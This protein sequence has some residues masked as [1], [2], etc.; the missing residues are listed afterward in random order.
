MPPFPK[1]YLHLLDPAPPVD[2][3]AQPPP[4]PPKEPTGA[5]PPSPPPDD[6]KFDD[7]D[8]AFEKAGTLP[9][10]P[11][12]GAKPPPKPEG[13]AGKPPAATPPPSPKPGDPPPEPNRTPKELRAEKDR[14]AEELKVEKQA[15]ADLEAK[16]AEYER[17]GK[18]TE[19]LQALLDQRQKDLDKLN[20]ELRALKQE[21]SPEFKEKYDKPFDR[22]AK[23]AES[24][25]KGMTKVDGT[26]A[27]FD[28]DFVPL[29]RMPYNAAYARAREVFGDDMAPAVMQ[30][31]AELQKLDFERREAFEEE[32]KGWAEKQKVEEGKLVVERE[33]LQKA[34]VATNKELVETVP[35]YQLPV[36]DKEL[37]DLR[38]EGEKIVDAQPK[39]VE[40]SVRKN[41]HIRIRAALFGP[42]QLQIK[43]LTA[44]VAELEAELAKHKPRQPNPDPTRT[45]T[46]AP[47]DPALSWE[48]QAR[49]ELNLA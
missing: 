30:R 48:Q 14:L 2:K 49:K 3:G 1:L 32:K 28:T 27:N 9:P 23:Y 18:D 40:Q 4:A 41:A 7:I 46:E 34:W 20:G 12:E 44:K 5:T 10:K 33:K 19:G 15:K 38:V 43:R 8:K 36:D 25:I 17:K 29:Y 24:V 45:G 21:A 16:I 35:A 47:P 13:G 22:A 6:A 31:V 42:N 11:A 39:S 37:N 26:P